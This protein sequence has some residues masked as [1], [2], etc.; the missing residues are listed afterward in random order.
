[1]PVNQEFTGIFVLWG[2]PWRTQIFLK[3]LFY[4]YLF[5]LFR[6]ERLL[7]LNEYYLILVIVNQM[8]NVSYEIETTVIFQHVPTKYVG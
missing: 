8:E 5:S 7:K 3:K 2:T 1:M 6:S 4:S